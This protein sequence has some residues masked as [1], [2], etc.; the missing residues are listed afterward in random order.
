LLK[1][2]CQLAP[3]LTASAFRCTDSIARITFEDPSSDRSESVRDIYAIWQNSASEFSL[4]CAVT[5]RLEFDRQSFQA[6][7]K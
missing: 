2:S 4:R 7:R 1:V 6:N 5:A 3:S